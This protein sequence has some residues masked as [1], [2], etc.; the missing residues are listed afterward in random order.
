MNAMIVY[1]EK[2]S[3]LPLVCASLWICHYLW[4]VYRACLDYHVQKQDRKHQRH[5]EKFNR[6]LK[7]IQ[8][9]LAVLEE[10]DKMQHE[11]FT[12]LID[13]VRTDLFEHFT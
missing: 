13:R 2:P 12:Q 11:H 1:T 4:T 8:R 3:I 10:T 9:K 7:K 5:K 6:W